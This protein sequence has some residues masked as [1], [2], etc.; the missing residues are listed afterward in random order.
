MSRQVTP[1]SQMRMSVSVPGAGQPS[2]L[3]NPIPLIALT[4]CKAPHSKDRT[5]AEVVLVIID[6]VV[7]QDTTS[8]TSIK[9]QCKVSRKFDNINN[10]STTKK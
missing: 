8:T 4:W 9:R 1:M 6:D 10:Q 7:N 3:L 2:R 5:K